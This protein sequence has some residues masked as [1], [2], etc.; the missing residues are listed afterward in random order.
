M[1]GTGIVVADAEE[2]ARLVPKMETIE[3]GDA[4]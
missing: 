3:P 4:P 1:V 2:T